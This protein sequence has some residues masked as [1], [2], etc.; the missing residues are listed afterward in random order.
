MQLGERALRG[1]GGP[2]APLIAW[3]AATFGHLFDVFPQ[4]QSGYEAA[5]SCLHSG[6][7]YGKLMNYL[8]QCG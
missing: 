3:Q 5:N 2:A 7:C 8:I 4:V 6:A 1:Q